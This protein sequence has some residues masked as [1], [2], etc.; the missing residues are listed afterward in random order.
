MFH[1]WQFVRDIL[2]MILR[3]GGSFTSGNRNISE[4]LG[5]IIVPALDSLGGH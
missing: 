3:F 4:N 1:Y 5:D 2:T